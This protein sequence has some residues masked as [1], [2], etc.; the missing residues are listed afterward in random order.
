MKG[1]QVDPDPDSDFDP[2]KIESEHAP[3]GDGRQ[4]AAPEPVDR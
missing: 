3:S 4:A 2:G 1:P